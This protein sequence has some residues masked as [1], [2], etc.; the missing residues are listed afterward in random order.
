MNRDDTTRAACGREAART[1]NWRLGRRSGP[2][3]S[4]PPATLRA[5]TRDG[6]RLTAAA[7]DYA[8]RGWHVFPLWPGSK[9]PAVPDQWE[10][11][12][13]TD[14]DLIRRWWSARP[15]NIGIAVGPSGLY[16]VDLDVPKP[17]RPPMARFAGAAATTATTATAQVNGVADTNAIRDKTATTATT[18]GDGR[19]AF[20]ALCAAHGQPIPADTYTVATPTG[21]LHLYYVHP[22]G[23][24]LRNT[25]GGLGPWIDTRGPA[26][27]G[28]VAG[29]YVVAPPSAITGRPYRVVRAQPPV[30]LPGWLATL[31]A[32]AVSPVP[33]RPVTVTLAGSDRRT[34]YLAAALSRE[35]EHVLAAPAGGRN[36]AV[37]GAAAALGQLVAGGALD[38][39]TVAA[40][41][42]PAAV[43]IGLT[44][45]EA[46]KA[47]H[48]GLRT[49]A[50]RPRMV[51]R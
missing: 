23:P 44:D 4:A 27:P 2:D 19:Q 47:I 50:N 43:A 30:A 41:L 38:A 28:R 36:R 35:V 46:R 25:V 29:G 40:V 10:R 48:N 16:V 39:G 9:A 18:P 26:A 22:A 34:G 12:A 11:R 3:G 51:A 17:G 24:P 8:A 31:L 49:G 15:Y 5:M 45:A 37:W 33:A 21:G 13:T 20:A 1:T 7:V 14:L 42:E 32:P 6:D